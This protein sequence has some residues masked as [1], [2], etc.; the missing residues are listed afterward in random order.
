MASQ[1]IRATI[2]KVAPHFKAQAWVSSANSFKEISLEDYKSKW[3]LLFFYPL[4][5]T[6]VCPTEIV[7]FSNK[8]KH[9]RQ[10]NCE[11]V[12]CS[13]DSH[14]VHR[15]WTL[16][17]RDEGGLGAIDIPLLADVKKEIADKYGVLND[18]GLALR[19]TFLIDDNQ[20][21]RH[22]SVNDLSVG[23]NVDEYLRLLQVSFD[24]FR[25]S[26]TPPSTARS[27]PPDG[28]RATPQ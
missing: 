10:H 16:E 15:R 26:S 11:V 24:L 13:I 23:R 28:N 17:P 14:F 7:E 1:V 27:A 4:D 3:L 12:G 25:H 8:A 6:F 2:G 20:I 21:V 5:F 22:T 9:F 18:A 19:G